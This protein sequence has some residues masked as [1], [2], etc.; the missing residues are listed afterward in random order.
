M[1]KSLQLKDFFDFDESF[2][3]FKMEILEKQV[4]GKLVS[5][6]LV[7]TFQNLYTTID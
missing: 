5:E 1:E 6:D 7:K 2:N 3:K 4:E